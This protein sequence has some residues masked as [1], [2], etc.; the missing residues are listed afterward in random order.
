MVSH[1]LVSLSHSLPCTTS[2]KLFYTLSGRCKQGPEVWGRHFQRCTTK[3][4]RLTSPYRLCS[5]MVL[6]VDLNGM[7][8]TYSSPLANEMFVASL[9]LSIFRAAPFRH[10]SFHL[11]PKAERLTQT[12]FDQ[13]SEASQIGKTG[14]VP[15][16]LDVDPAAFLRERSM[17][18][19]LLSENDA[20]RRECNQKP[21]G[22]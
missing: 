8:R 13:V 16:R 18:T 11:F 19:R 9:D 21:L 15:V 22:G 3:W 2:C 20:D 4:R 17:T 12:P 5:C 6:D 1:R 10:S 7:G 14:A